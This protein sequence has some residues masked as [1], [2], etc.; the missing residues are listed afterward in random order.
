MS[1]RSNQ[2]HAAIDTTPS[3]GDSG[4]YRSPFDRIKQVRPD[5][6]EFWSARRLQ[7][8]MGYAKWHNLVTV[9]ARAMQAASNT[10][11]DVG[12]EFSQIEPLPE[13]GN[14]STDGRFIG[15]AREDYHLS[16]QAAY[17][18]AMNGDPNK[19]QVAAAQAYFAI[20]TQEAE[21]VEQRA[22]GLP[23][24][25]VALHALVDQ[26]AAIEVE[27]QRQADELRQIGA[28]VG[29]IEGAH[30]WMSALGY[31]R[32]NGFVTERTYL[33]RVGVRAGRILRQD[34]KQPG[35]TQHPAFGTVNTYPLW[36]LERAF[37]EVPVEGAA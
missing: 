20:R 1:D 21:V 13:A 2:E 6:S 15:G 19:P 37:G 31:A 27:Q 10:G 23:A 33:Q 22:K 9:I 7:G 5:G 16:R 35:K 34:G 11:I 24:W 4:L 14:R 17:L 25:A 8:L 30:D 29:A 3:Q 26:Q 18:V 28:R 36:V 12:R 32:I